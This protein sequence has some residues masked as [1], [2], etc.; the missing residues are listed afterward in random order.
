MAEGNPPFVRASAWARYAR[1]AD[2]VEIGGRLESIETRLREGTELER[3]ALV[4]VVRALAPPVRASLLA[5][6]VDDER[7]A[8]RVAAG[9]AA[10]DVPARFWRSRDRAALARAVREH[11]ERLLANAER[12]E[13][14]VG[15]GTL[16]LASGEPEA[17]R[18]AFERVIERSP[19]FVPAY[20]NLAD[21][22]RALG[23]DAAS[24]AW[25]RR[26]V[27]LA[28]DV[29]P[30]RYAL[31]LALHRTGERVESIEQLQRAA[32]L[33]PDDGSYVLAWALAL[34]AAGRSDDAIAA[35]AAAVDRGVSGG[36][37]T[38]T[39]VTLLRDRGELD[40]ARTRAKAWAE[41]SPTDPRPR[42]LLR[43][44]AAPR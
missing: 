9:E 11:R 28:P 39:L 26:A 2:P 22:E 1:E 24:V 33:E 8:I 37:V 19:S 6:L 7:Y 15:L 30:V 41:R 21:L 17:A 29:A 43:E 20:V 13:A 31:G 4:D 42:A 10:L 36:D 27:E 40:R 5:S 35:L 14:G 18:A 25:L 23:R 3:L 34:D 32:A 44:L 12:P 38:L 16:A